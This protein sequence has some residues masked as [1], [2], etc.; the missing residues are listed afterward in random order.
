MQRLKWFAPATIS[1]RGMPTDPSRFRKPI[2]TYWV[3]VASYTTMGIG[4]VAS[5][6]PFLL[7]GCIVLWVTYR[8]GRSAIGDS[9]RA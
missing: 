9:Q 4:M 2:V 8:I 5:R 1:T 3:L 7:A 6:L